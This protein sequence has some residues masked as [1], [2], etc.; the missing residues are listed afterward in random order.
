LV[1]RHLGRREHDIGGERRLG[2]GGGSARGKLGLS[3]GIH[4]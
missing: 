3:F 1:C 4:F 2:R